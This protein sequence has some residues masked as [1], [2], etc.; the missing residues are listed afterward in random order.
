MLW[1]AEE[2][3]KLLAQCFAKNQ[4]VDVSGQLDFVV[5]NTA[6]FVDYN[7]PVIDFNGT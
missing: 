5:E 2:K 7:D 3:A 1:K 4:I 6:R